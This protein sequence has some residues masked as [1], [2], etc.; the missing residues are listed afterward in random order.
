MTLKNFIKA[1]L[2]PL[3]SLITPKV[4]FS[5]F[6]RKNSSWRMYTRG[7]N[8]P[9]NTFSL[10]ALEY[11]R[12]FV[13]DKGA[14]VFDVGGELGLEAQQL[15]VIVGDQGRV[16]TFECFP[17]HLETLGELAKKHPNITVI[18]KACWNKPET[19]TFY[20]GLT[21]GSGSAIAEVKGQ[22]G[23]QLANTEKKGFDVEAET[24]DVL[25]RKYAD[26]KPID[27]LKMDIEGAEYEALEGAKVLLKKT[28]KIVVAAYHIRDG[29][30][31][32]DK[33]SE[34]LKAAGFNVRI[35]ENDHVY[36]IRK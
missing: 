35:D 3:Y 13:P 8:V 29:V 7:I 20:E 1:L 5:Y 24:L 32:A 17:K 21:D 15:S 34:A 22:R 16:F 36:G 9:V 28:K 26:E 23:Q 11:F 14:T 18:D 25:W 2:F 4:G 31:T 33:V 12:H 6:Y 27:F 30:R 10:A 19:L